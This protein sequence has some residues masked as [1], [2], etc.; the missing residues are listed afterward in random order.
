MA[1][2]RT[3][4]P[5]QDTGSCTH[6]LIGTN[7]RGRRPLRNLI[8]PTLLLVILFWTSGCTN[9]REVETLGVEFE[10]DPAEAIELVERM[11]TAD[12][13][14]EEPGHRH[15]MQ[16]EKMP[17]SNDP[18]YLIRVCEDRGSYLVPLQTFKVNALTGVISDIEM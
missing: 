17:G 16:F 8:I 1:F 12:F 14:W 7:S 11:E 5:A 6:P 13:V 18:F 10:I 9:I 2:A 15:L 4:P 3:L